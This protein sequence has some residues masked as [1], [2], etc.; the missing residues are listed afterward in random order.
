MCVPVTI[1]TRMLVL[2]VS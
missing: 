2:H 1:L